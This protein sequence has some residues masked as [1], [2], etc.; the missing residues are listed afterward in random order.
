MPCIC[1]KKIERHDQQKIQCADCKVYFHTKCVNIKEC[2]IEF[3]KRNNKLFRCDQCTAYRRKS[4]QVNH[5]Q[6]S[7]SVIVSKDIITEP[8][9]DLD[10]NKDS[11]DI[12]LNLVYKEILELKKLNANA[13]SLISKLQNENIKL[14]Q[15]VEQL[16]IKV[17]DLEQNKRK[18]I[19]EITGIPNV[20][21]A[22]AL[23]KSLKFFSDGFGVAVEKEQIDYCYV[24]KIKNK[25]NTASSA[26]NNIASTA[27]DSSTLDIVCI[28][29]NSCSLK[30]TILSKKHSNKGKLTTQIFGEKQNIKNIFI[31][32]SLTSHTRALWK[33]ARDIKQT[34]RYKYL[35]VRNGTVWLR[36]ND[37]DPVIM[38]KSFEVLEKL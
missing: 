13:V 30:Q 24:K 10:C 3:M 17:N 31:N 37:G 25:N 20:T 12:T 27:D 1:N 19:V 15:R 32:E 7:T 26:A 11:K 16:E 23:D 22:D 33:A 36:K 28:K 5:S 21:N 34:N 2:D 8:L 18:K 6:Q 35:W 38:I 14:K 4:L 29:F 9:I